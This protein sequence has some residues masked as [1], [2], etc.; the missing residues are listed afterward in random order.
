MLSFLTS[1]ISEENTFQNPANDDDLLDAYSKTITKVVDKTSNSVVQIKVLKKPVQNANPR[2][3]QGQEA[4]GS[5]F[6]I[7]SD[8][9]VITNNHVVSNALKVEVGMMDGKI[10][11]AYVIGTDPYTDIAVLKI[12][13][14]SLKPL[15]FSDSD[16]LKV[17]Q[18]AVAIGNPLG[19]QY[20]VTAGVVSALGRTLRSETGRMIDDVIQTDAS[21]NPGNSGGPLVNSRG[22]VIGV[23]TAV[24]AQAQGICFAVS[25]NITK[26]VAGK[27]I[28]E[29][30]VKRAQLGIAGQVVNLSERMIAYN[31]LTKSTGVYISDVIPDANAKNDELR[32]ADIIIGINDISTASIEDLHRILNDE[33]INKVVIVNILRGGI[34]K[35]VSVLAGE[36]K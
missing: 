1:S 33:L 31:K 11:E 27:L 4:G 8:G 16:K 29:G 3:R 30:K 10:Y 13:G 15:A 24:I 22:E 6:I 14:D 9:F 23:N 36:L 34:S 28:L 20:T 32:R 21:L 7:S 12:Y 5:G 25:A 35:K 19:F 18:I 17:G 26:Y 2:L